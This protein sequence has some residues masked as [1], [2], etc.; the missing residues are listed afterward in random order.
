M[1]KKSKD[2]VIPD[3]RLMERQIREMQKII[4]SKGFETVEEANEYMN[5]WLKETGGKIPISEPETPQERAMELVY[6]AIES[7]GKRR[8]ELAQHA[9]AIDENCSEAYVLI[10]EET[11]RT[12]EQ[13][14]EWIEKAVRAS[15]NTLGPEFL[16]SD[17]YLGEYWRMLDARPYM[18]AR[19]MLAEIQWA[20]GER[21]EAV[22]TYQDLL[23]RN[24]GDNQGL[25]YKLVGWLIVLDRVDQALKL[26]KEYR[27]DS[28]AMLYAHALATFRKE[29][30][31]RKSKSRLRAAI[32]Q[33]PFFPAY[34]LGLRRLPKEIP[35]AYGMGS[36]E[37][38]VVLVVESIQAWLSVHGAMDFLGEVFVDVI[39]EKEAE[40]LPR[41]PIHRPKSA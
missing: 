3:Q 11:A 34:A 16:G 37:E 20:M 4:Q 25:R 35:P 1:V 15:E 13:A 38:G 2:L 26:I 12:P 24:P 19:A 21:E 41:G 29:G 32:E 27:E 23:R 17:E 8:L 22:A 30:S 6:Q 36:E 28:A 18:R 14:R 39:K 10:A 31:T 40:E 5:K 7:K 33:N 9:L